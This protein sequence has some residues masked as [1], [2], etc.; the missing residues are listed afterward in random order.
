M[1]D[2]LLNPEPKRTSTFVSPLQEGKSNVNEIDSAVFLKATFE[3]DPGKGLELLFRRYYNPLCSHAVRFVYSKQIA[4][5][6]V[7]EVF[8]QFY[9][10]RAY[11]NITSSYTSYLFRC[12]R[13]ECYTYMRREF[14]KMA[15]LEASEENT[16][17]TYHQQPDAEIHYN[18]LF[19]K[20]NEVIAR[21][22]MQCQKVFLLSRFENKKYHEIAAELHISPKTVEVHI[23]KAL[24]HLR[25]ALRGEWMISAG[26]TLVSFI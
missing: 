8:F 23:S 4:E 16:I 17:S 19:L 6:L 24:K 1:H 10:T 12:V 7:S 15:S 3:Q 20:V 13:N 2:P 22:P 11:E 5:D 9:R 25:L 18:N 26:L 14:G 21:L